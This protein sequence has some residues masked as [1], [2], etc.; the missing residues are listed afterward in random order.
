MQTLTTETPVAPGLETFTMSVGMVV[1]VRVI[2][3]SSPVDGV[4]LGAEYQVEYIGEEP[5]CLDLGQNWYLNP[6]DVFLTR[7]GNMDRALEWI[8]EKY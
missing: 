3:E 5:V 2:K 8:A 1:P 6:G 4:W 7:K